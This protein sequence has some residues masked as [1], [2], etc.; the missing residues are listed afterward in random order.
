[1]AADFSFSPE[2]ALLILELQEADIAEL[3]A[4][5]KGKSFG[6]DEDQALKLYHDELARL[7]QVYED[8]KVARSIAAAVATDAPVLEA[9]LEEERQARE[10]RQLALRLEA[11]EN[12]SGDDTES[13]Y[14]SA[15]QSGRAA[16]T[17]TAGPSF[18]ST[19]EPFSPK[20]T[21]TCVIC[22]GDFK[23]IEVITVNCRLSHRY[24]RGCLRDLFL[25]AAKDESLFPP[26]C[27]GSV[28]PISLV[29]PY[30]SH[31]EL[32]NYYA[33]MREY[34]TVNRLYCSN[35]TCSTFLGPAQPVTTGVQCNKCTHAT[36]SA[37]KAPWHGPFG[38]CGASA[39]DE[40]ARVLERD[41]QCKRCPRCQ[42]M[43]DLDTGCWH[44]TCRCRHEFCFLCLADWKTCNCVLWDETRLYREAQRDVEQRGHGEVVGRG[45]VQEAMERRV[46][47]VEGV[48][49]AAP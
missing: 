43:I 31:D 42:R 49:P 30:L 18:S 17:S 35:S 45:A 12:A 11:E 26:R 27:D 47:E 14:Q 37:C 25:A 34:T 40:A 9:L 13:V 41:H 29:Q 23:S 48:P 5:R 20:Q 15:R 22:M 44:V 21:A 6:S 39:D 16:S 28:I 46:Q 7:A 8:D 1:M 24:C 19:M 36:C 32:A 10:D 3:S 33:R 2:D 4:S 38:L